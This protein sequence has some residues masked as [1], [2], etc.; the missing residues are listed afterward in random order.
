[1][2]VFAVIPSAGNASQL[3]YYIHATTEATIFDGVQ[4]HGSNVE[5]GVRMRGGGAE[6]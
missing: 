6:G 5:T 2:V 4:V 3:A 1:M